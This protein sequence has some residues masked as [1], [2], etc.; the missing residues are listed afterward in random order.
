[1]SA[2][3]IASLLITGAATVYGLALLIFVPIRWAI[4][5][6]AHRLEYEQLLREHGVYRSRPKDWVR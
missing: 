2:L 3:A 4:R 1:M 6:R 5:R